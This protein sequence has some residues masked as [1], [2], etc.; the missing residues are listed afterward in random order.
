MR[1]PFDYAY[2]RVS[3]TIPIYQGRLVPFSD[4]EQKWQRITGDIKVRG[5]GCHMFNVCVHVGWRLV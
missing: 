1:R 2:T 4:E 3:D 5:V